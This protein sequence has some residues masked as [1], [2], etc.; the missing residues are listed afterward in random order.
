MLFYPAYFIYPP[1]GKI[2]VVNPEI[3]GGVKEV[4]TAEWRRKK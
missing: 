1:R 2:D 4:Y 3:V